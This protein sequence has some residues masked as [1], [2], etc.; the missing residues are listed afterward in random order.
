MFK[1]DLI[2]ESDDDVGEDTGAL[3]EEDLTQSL[4][5]AGGPETPAAAA[6]GG[7]KKEGDKKEEGAPAGGEKK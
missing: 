7:E 1:D 4:A 3:D 6:G 5:V 2:Y